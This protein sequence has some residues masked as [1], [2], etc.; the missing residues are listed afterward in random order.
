VAVGVL[1]QG[2]TFAA[3]VALDELLRQPLQQRVAG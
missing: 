2:R 3:A 1:G